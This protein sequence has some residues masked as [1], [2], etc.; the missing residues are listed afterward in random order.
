MTYKTA[1]C[2]CLPSCNSIKYDFNID[3]TRKITDTEIDEM[4]FLERPDYQYIAEIEESIYELKRITNMSKN[5][6]LHVW[7]RCERY[8]RHEY[9]HVTI[10]ID[11]TTYLK[12]VKSLKYTETDKLSIVG[13]TL[14]LFSGFS[15]IVIFELLYWV[16]TISK[17]LFK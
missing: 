10:R 2:S 1:S 17:M 8:L 5:I 9:A 11:G 12:R 14:G 7:E 4:C 3:L 6:N 16:V 15:F 13:G